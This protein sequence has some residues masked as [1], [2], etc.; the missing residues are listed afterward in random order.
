MFREFL[1]NLL[2]CFSTE[3][4]DEFTEIYWALLFHGVSY[5]ISRYLSP[6]EINSYFPK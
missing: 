2:S 6:L 5:H 4:I 3:L 1:P